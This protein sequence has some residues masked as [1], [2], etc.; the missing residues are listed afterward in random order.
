MTYTIVTMK[1]IKG[2]PGAKK[3]FDALI[4]LL[5]DEKRIS[6]QTPLVGVCEEITAHYQRKELEQKAG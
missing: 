2:G 6:D 3:H 5:Y 1:H 4:K